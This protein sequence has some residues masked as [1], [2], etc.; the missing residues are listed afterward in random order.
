ML[1]IKQKIVKIALIDSGIDYK[2]TEFDSAKIYLLN[3]CKDQ[4]GHGT[5]VAAIIHKVSPETEIYVYRL[6]DNDDNIIDAEQL[7]EALIFLQQFKFDIIHLSCGVVVSDKLD[8]LRRVC[9]DLV[10]EGTIIVCAYDDYGRISYPAAFENVIGVDWDV[11]CSDGLQYSF[12][13]NSPVNIL[14][15][16]ALMRLPWL[17]G[18][19]KTVAGSSFA[20][21]YITGLVANFLKN[22]ENPNNIMELLRCKSTKKIFVDKPYYSK[23]DLNFAINKAIIY[24]VN[25]EVHNLLTYANLLPFDIVGVYDQAIFRNVGKRAEDICGFGD[26]HIV[27]ESEKQIQW[28][29]DFDTLVLGHT[30]IY[31]QA[32]KKD[33]K[34]EFMEKCITHRKK[35]ICF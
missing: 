4:I 5:A 17:N 3:E 9:I 32:L 20:A 33:I 29:S 21:P 31:E 28:E 1:Q 15:T 12:V 18:G 6:F 22:G 30:K 14:G 34:K 8:L 25:K 26:S 13:E 10:N 27:V 35:Y 11:T 24:P 2:R 19:Y 16:G 7:I 23:V